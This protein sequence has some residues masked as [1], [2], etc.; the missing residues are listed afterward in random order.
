MPDLTTQ[1]KSTLAAVNAPESALLALIISHPALA[2]PVRV[3]ND[4]QDITICGELYRAC[5]FQLDP[6]E[7]VESQSPKA[8]LT[9]DNI[10]KEL[11]QWVESSRGG[12]GS[13]VTWLSVMRS[14][15]NIIES[16]ITFELDGVT[17]DHF[18][19]T[20]T[21]GLENLF[22]TDVCAMLFTPATA[23]GIFT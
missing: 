6:P 16:E 12:S 3:V 9:I 1:T 21:M 13:T 5:G 18:T 11:M 10:G 20:A 15:P 4:T 19:V 7:D 2:E 8:T 17:A 14:R 23:P 22:G